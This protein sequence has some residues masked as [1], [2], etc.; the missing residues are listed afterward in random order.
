MDPNI[1]IRLLHNSGLTDA[2]IEGSDIV[3]TDPS[4]IFPAFDAFF[5]Y[6]WIAAMVLTVIIL[7]GWGVLYIKNGAKA[8]S[9]FNNAKS[10]LLMLCILS[11][12]KPIVNVVYHEDALFSQ[13]CEKKHVSLESVEKLLE[14]RKKQFAKSDEYLLFEDFNIDDTGIVVPEDYEEDDEYCDACE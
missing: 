3:F 2:T 1:Y 9:L 7:F 4:C 14:Q 12:V 13:L 11:I 10:L 6:A 5:N 8:T